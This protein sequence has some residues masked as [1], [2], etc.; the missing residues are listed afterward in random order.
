MLTFASDE[1]LE[2]NAAILKSIKLIFL[3]P[4]AFHMAL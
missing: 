2:D 4:V 1:G 3:N